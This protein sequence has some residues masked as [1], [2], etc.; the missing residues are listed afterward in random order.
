M[1]VK[2]FLI[3][4]VINL[5]IGC[6]SS[7]T[8]LYNKLEQN[9]KDTKNLRA[10]GEKKIAL[11]SYKSGFEGEDCELVAKA[12]AQVIGAST[13]S[14]IYKVAA[15]YCVIGEAERKI[16]V[17]NLPQI[18]NDIDRKYA[19]EDTNNLNIPPQQ[20]QES[21]T[22]TPAP[23]QQL[24]EPK[25]YSRTQSNSIPKIYPPQQENVPV[26]DKRDWQS[27]IESARSE[28]QY[29]DERVATF[30]QDLE[31]A[32]RNPREARDSEESLRDILI[33]EE[34][35]LNEAKQTYKKIIEEAKKEG[36]S[37]Q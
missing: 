20:N 19:S 15:M 8:Q 10:Q 33:K 31:I 35:K 32:V 21:V 12:T 5:V 1:K 26:R 29:Q 22:E 2:P 24:S 34:R 9:I 13:G 14:N 36:A 4:L 37:I 27:L 3:L 18:F 11:L 17:N 6:S 23:A 16:K 25:S 28:V 30:K 7:D